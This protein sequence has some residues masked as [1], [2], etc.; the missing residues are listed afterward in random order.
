MG[1]VL[2]GEKVRFK[3]D[4]KF[5]QFRQNVFNVLV[6]TGHAQKKKM[7]ENLSMSRRYLE[8]KTSSKPV[9]S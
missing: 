6:L 4:P 3:S 1:S 8:G 7:E 5:G 2:C 9:L